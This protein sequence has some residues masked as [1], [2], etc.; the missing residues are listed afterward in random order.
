LQHHLNLAG[1]NR[2]LFTSEAT[3]AIFQATKGIPRALGRLA[4]ACLQLAAEQQL[5]Q[6]DAALVEA[7]S[8][9]WQ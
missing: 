1:C 6:V 5:E 3:A 2:P 7:A 9:D 8:L 4:T